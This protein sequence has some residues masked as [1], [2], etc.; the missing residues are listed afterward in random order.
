MTDM[1]SGTRAPFLFGLLVSL[2]CAS[3]G[4]DDRRGDLEGVWL[5]QPVTMND[6]LA[7][8]GDGS[9][10]NEQRQFAPDGRPVDSLATLVRLYGSFTTP[11]DSLAVDIVR[12]Q[13]FGWGQR[14]TQPVVTDGPTVLRDR[15]GLTLG[16]GTFTI[17]GPSLSAPAT[18][19]R[20]SPDPTRFDLCGPQP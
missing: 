9:F 11:G 7:L 10:R 20:A 3:Q 5:L 12:Q 18:Y 14:L 16:N 15:F 2:A 19:R 17:S 6:C 4:P 13:T 8:T 1:V